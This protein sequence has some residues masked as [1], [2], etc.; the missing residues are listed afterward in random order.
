MKRV[1][2][3]ALT[4]NP[5]GGMSVVREVARALSLLGIEVDVYLGT[6]RSKKAIVDSQLEG[7]KARDFLPFLPAYL[8]LL[9]GKFLFLFKRGY[10]AVLTPNYHS[11]CMG[12]SVTLH[13]NL[14]SF[15]HGMTYNFHEN[16]IKIR[17]E[18]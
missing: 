15:H 1:A 18:F 12:K 13:I 14:F 8:R 6:E 16:T 7:V 4:I 2:I 3:N 9:V 5:G 17:I 11:L 10:Y